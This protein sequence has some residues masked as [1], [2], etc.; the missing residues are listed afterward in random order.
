[1]VGAVLDLIVGGILSLQVQKAVASG[2]LDKII[3]GKALADN[4]RE[5]DVQHVR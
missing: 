2:F 4:M 3:A 1:M 5:V